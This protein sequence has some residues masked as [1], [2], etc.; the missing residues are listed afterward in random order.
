MYLR[1]KSKKAH[2]NGLLRK[3]LELHEKEFTQSH[4]HNLEVPEHNHLRPSKVER[5]A[6]RTESTFSVEK[7]L[8]DKNP[9]REEKTKGNKR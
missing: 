5:Q 1:S 8:K 9:E 7:G 2:K 3:N 6:P 4:F